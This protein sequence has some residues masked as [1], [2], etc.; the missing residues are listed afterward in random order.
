MPKLL[1]QVRSLIR[2]KHYSIR[3]EQAY[4]HWIRQ[5]ILFHN[6]RHP[7]EMAEPEITA[8]LSYLAT[9]KNV[10]AST[11][12]QAL[13]AILFLYRE[14][15]DRPLDRLDHIHRAKKSQ[16]LP[17]VFTKDEAQAVLAQLD[18]TLWLMASLLYGSG[19]RLMECLRLR[20][21]DV[22]FDYNQIT[23]RD[24]KG[25]KD[26]VTVLPLAIKPVLQRHLARVKALHT[27][28]L[29]DGFGRV[30]LPNALARKYQ[31][32]DREWCWQYVFPSA[33]RSV[34]PRAGEVRRHHANEKSLQRAIGEAV[35]RAGIAKPAT[36][37]TFRHS[38]ATHL[39]EDGYDIRT[40]QEL[41]GHSDVRTTMIYIHV[42]NRGGRAVK[43]PVDRG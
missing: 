2:L 12:N 1:D 32:A 23:V 4:L 6:K 5:F 34:D 19:L 25:G 40:V 27:R 35:R 43:S 11:Q 14:V 28:D 41:L 8:F 21:K 18:G 10:S 3:T 38:F 24:G 16:R 20:V 7:S 9:A 29:E 36:C 15:L 22:D 26:R 31:Q 13:S 33:K 42:L 39:I 37:H 30:Y 17:L